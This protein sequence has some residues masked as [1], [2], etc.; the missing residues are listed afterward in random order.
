MSKIFKNYVNW[1]TKKSK[2]HESN[3]ADRQEQEERIIL[4]YT[5]LVNSQQTII[6]SIINIYIFLF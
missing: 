3:E 5:L 6:C 4:R 1:E 2:C